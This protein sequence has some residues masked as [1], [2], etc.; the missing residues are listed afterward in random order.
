MLEPL[1]ALV[2]QRAQVVRFFLGIAFSIANNRQIPLLLGDLLN[3]TGNLREIG[4]GVI[5]HQYGY[6]VTALHTQATGQ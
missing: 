1:F 6:Q 2:L 4:V 3:A 5:A